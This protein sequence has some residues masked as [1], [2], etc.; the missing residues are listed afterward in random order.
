MSFA[1]ILILFA[2]IYAGGIVWSLATQPQGFNIT[3]T[4][5]DA[6]VITLGVTGT[7]S[8]FYFAYVFIVAVL[9]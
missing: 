7:L 2:M 9:S 3:Q 6:W 1:S 4:L 8:V 5:A